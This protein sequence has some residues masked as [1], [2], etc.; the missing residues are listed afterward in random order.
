MQAFAPHLYPEGPGY[1]PRTFR[2]RWRARRW[3]R[4]LR[5]DGNYVKITPE[6]P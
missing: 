6:S 4:L 1:A 3:S 2:S 5:R